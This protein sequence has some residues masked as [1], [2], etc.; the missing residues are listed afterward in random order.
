MVIA[1]ARTS[2]IVIRLVGLSGLGALV[3]CLALGAPA[4]RA[5][6]QNRPVAITV[7]SEQAMIA[8]GTLAPRT[9]DHHNRSPPW[10]PVLT[11][12]RN[13]AASDPTVVLLR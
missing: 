13:G 1:L 2:T 9:S 10:W 12:T 5:R 6:N 3:L 4:Q 11:A 7:Q 8:A